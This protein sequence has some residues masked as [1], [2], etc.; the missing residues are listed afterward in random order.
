MGSIR[1]PA[2][3]RRK[4][5]ADGKWAYFWELPGWARPPAVRH[6]RTCPVTSAA[7]GTNA[8]EA[9]DKA[10]AI[11]AAFTEWRNGYEGDRNKK[12][13]IAWLF[14]W[15]RKQERFTSKAV[16][17]R[18]DYRKIMDMLVEIET[19]RGP[20]GKVMA[21]SIDATRADSLYRKVQERGVRQATY[22][23]QVCRLVWTW[24]VRYGK[25]TGVKENPFRGMGLTSKAVKGNRETSR[26]EYELYKT[27]AREL[28]YQ[29][30]ATAAALGFECCQ[31]VWDVFCLRD[32]ETGEES[33]GLL[34]EGYFPGEAIS[35]IQSKT[36]NYV[37]IELSTIM[38]I[39]GQPE[40]VMLYPELEAELVLSRAAAME[41]LAEAGMNPD[42]QPAGQ[43]IVE[44]RSG[45]PYKHRRM[46][47]VHRE[48][49]DA[50]GLPKDMT[51]TGFRHGGITEI[52]DTGEADVRA[53]SGHKTLSVTTIYNKANAEKSRRIA[54]K[55][56]EHLRQLA[57]KGE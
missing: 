18:L 48:I 52:G 38:S 21:S 41:R 15:Y 37:R 5:L 8:G 32:P 33:P 28:G 25:T 54:V 36:R 17:T 31:R 44:E 34:W 14:E 35:L 30:M 43:I 4:R 12:G 53:I 3:T 9:I 45:R 46:S 2:Y 16:K 22:A 6:G 42:H 19:K 55:R 40:I 11:N 57:G 50:A 49:C 51:F 10:D 24:A 23:M 26:A 29:S 7:L 56:R 39:E 27:T 47:E 20:L 1:L 13:S